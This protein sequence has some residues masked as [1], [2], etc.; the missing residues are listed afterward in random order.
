MLHGAVPAN[1]RAAQPTVTRMGLVPAEE[2]ESSSQSPKAGIRV[3]DKTQQNSK[4]RP[5]QNCN[6]SSNEC[7][8]RT[9]TDAP[10]N[11]ELTFPM[12]NSLN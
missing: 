12:Q 8:N 10:T 9:A 6:E 2:L 7:S 5:T 11:P 4:E 3:A 1:S